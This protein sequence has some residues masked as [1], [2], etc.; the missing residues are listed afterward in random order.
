MVLPSGPTGM[1]DGAKVEVRR[2]DGY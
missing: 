2:V 1:R